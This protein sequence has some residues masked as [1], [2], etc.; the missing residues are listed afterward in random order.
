MS[1]TDAVDYLIR[2]IGDNSKGS[3]AQL[4]AVEA[5]GEAGGDQAIDHLITFAS[6]VARGSNAHM[7]VIKALGRA[8][9]NA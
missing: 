5:L 7:A 8:A 4:A 1:K 3:N 2:A 6:D 9:R